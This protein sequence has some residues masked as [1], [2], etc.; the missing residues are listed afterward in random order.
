MQAKEQ[1]FTLIELIVVITILGILAAFALPRFMNMQEDARIA[2]LKGL[3]GSLQAS[4]AMVHGKALARGVTTGT[5]AIG[6]GQTVTLVN[7]YPSAATVSN[8]IQDL[9]GFTV[10]T[11]NPATFAPVGVANRN[12]C[13]VRYTQATATLPPVIA[14]IS[15]N[16]N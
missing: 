4:S 10:T 13:Q 12:N 6:D 8:T 15:T 14:T 1:G 7:G 5:L 2:T 11:G 3:A 16:C 9:N